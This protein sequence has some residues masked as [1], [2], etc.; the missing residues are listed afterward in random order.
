MTLFNAFEG[1]GTEST[2]RAI[3]RAVTYAKDINDRLQVSIANQPPVIVYAGN[4]SANIAQNNIAPYNAM[5]WNMMDAREDF[6]IS[7]Q[8]NFII[9]RNRW[10]F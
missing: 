10:T 1:I 5:S 8:Q 3:L 4:T 9:A 7:A 2:L 6:M